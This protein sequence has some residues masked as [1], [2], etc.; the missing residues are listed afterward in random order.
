MSALEKHFAGRKQEQ[1]PFSRLFFQDRQSQIPL[2]HLHH[3][4]GGCHR[5]YEQIK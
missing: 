5:I 4:S 1:F 2:L 3:E